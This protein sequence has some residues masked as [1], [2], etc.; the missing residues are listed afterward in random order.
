MGS[1]YCTAWSMPRRSWSLE[2]IISIQ[3]FSY[4]VL[5]SSRAGYIYSASSEFVIN[6]QCIKY[7]KHP[8]AWSHSGHWS[9]WLIK[10]NN[11]PYV[12][13]CAGIIFQRFS[14]CIWAWFNNNDKNWLA[15]SS[16]KLCTNEAFMFKY[17]G[18]CNVATN[19]CWWRQASYVQS[20]LF[21]C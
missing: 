4:R 17:L 13:P 11:S 1:G 2:F 10:Y 7:A 8:K 19:R 6:W 12:S 20:V 16:V 14:L 9:K 15:G 5:F 21:F 18:T 3:A